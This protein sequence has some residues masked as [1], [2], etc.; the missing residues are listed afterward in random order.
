ML[1]IRLL[2]PVVRGVRKVFMKSP[3]REGVEEVP[4]DGAD[5]YSDLTPYDI[6]DADYEEIKREK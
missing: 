1:L 4:K 6:E 3:T 5:S 2:R